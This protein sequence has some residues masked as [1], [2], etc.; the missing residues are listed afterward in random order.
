[1]TK[2]DELIKALRYG[3]VFEPHQCGGVVDQQ[4][5][6]SVMKMAADE[7][8]RTIAELVQVKQQARAGM[9]LAEL[10]SYAEIVG[11][12]GVNRP[13]IRKWCDNVFDAARAVENAERLRESTSEAASSTI[14][15]DDDGARE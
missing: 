14:N 5:T 13:G 9:E 1:M 6:E 15:A 12:I 8:E 10:S 2:L 11:G 7:L 3:C 4:A